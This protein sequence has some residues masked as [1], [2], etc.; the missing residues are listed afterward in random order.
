M[1]FREEN[2]Q[3]L[4]DNQGYFVV[5]L[6][7]AFEVDNLIAFHSEAP[8]QDGAFTA[9]A[10]LEETSIRQSISNKLKNA[11]DPYLN[12]LV[13]GANV[14]GASFV[15]KSS[16]HNEMLQPHQDWNIVDER[17][18]RSY[19][20]WIPLR[21]TNIE[22]GAVM[23]M[24]KS[25]KWITTI[26]HQSIPC[27]FREVYNELIQHMITLEIP[28]GHALIYDHALIHASHANVSNESRI[29]IAAGMKSQEADMFFYWNENGVVEVYNAD[30][31]HYMEENIFVRP[32]KLIK[33]KDIEYA[34]PSV[35]RR[36]LY[37]FLG[38]EFK[39]KPTGGV[40][41]WFKVYSPINVLKEIVYRLNSIKK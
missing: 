17:Y 29:A 39:E 19:N 9:T 15:V 27:A 20:I 4:L 5:P 7:S 1:E 10:H 12:D 25:H 41:L 24:P 6:L 34:F 14:L 8:K 40:K 23:V 31:N 22:N 13:Q 16:G 2:M 21:N 32:T 30:E 26:R 3:H 35:N 38:K 37:S 33:R 28:A 36:M 18:Y 11:I